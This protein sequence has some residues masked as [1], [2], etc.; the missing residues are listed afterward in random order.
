MSLAEDRP[1]SGDGDDILAAEY[2]V[3][4]LSAEERAATARRIDADA[5]FARLVDLWEARLA[6][7]AGGYAEA[8]VPP[9]VKHAID[10]R[11][12][13]A[14]ESR[15]RRGGRA[16]FWSSLVL[17]R[18]LAGI[19]VLALAIVL[20]APYLPDRRAPAEQTMMVAALSARDSDVQY[21]AMLDK[22]TGQLGLSHVSG[23]RAAGHDF[24]LWM[25]E[26]DRSPV[27]MGVIPVGSSAHMALDAE[28][29]GKLSAGTVLAISLEPSGGSPTGSPTGPVVAAGDMRQI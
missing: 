17:W 20:A 28:T 27:S 25:I 7:L 24:E 21:V 4:V 18:G 16:R 12:G 9:H 2:V 6:P 26:P 11:L 5:A 23:D 13:I 8:T 10:R 22:A 3:G 15:Q 19:A 1:G 14:V 29:M